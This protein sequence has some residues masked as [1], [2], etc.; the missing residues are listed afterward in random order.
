MDLNAR[1]LEQVGSDAIDCR[2]G[3]YEGCVEL[4]EC[5]V[6]YLPRRFPTIFEMDGNTIYNLATGESYDVS[7][8]YS[9]H[10]TLFIA[11]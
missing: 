1:V 2:E 9:K 10:H 4:L 11:G 5:L 6:E 3:G 8:P 7:K